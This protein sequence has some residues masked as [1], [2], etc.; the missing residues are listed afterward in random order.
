MEQILKV[1]KSEEY[2][3]YIFISYEEDNIVGINFHQGI[4]AIDY[5]YVKPCSY[6]TET[7][8]RM[9]NSTPIY[10][11][12]QEEIYEIINDAIE[13]VCSVINYNQCISYYMIRCDDAKRPSTILPD[14]HFEL[15]D[16][17]GLQNYLEI[18]NANKLN[19]DLL[20]EEFDKNNEEVTKNIYLINNNHLNN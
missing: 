10:N 15:D 2:D 16:L 1:L 4:D 7:F 14:K 12:K 9:I 17:R 18:C 6:T 5:Y 3:R 11:K 19:Y 20:I 13:V 8:L